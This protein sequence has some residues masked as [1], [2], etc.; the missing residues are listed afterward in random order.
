MPYK[1]VISNAIIAH[2]VWRSTL[3]ACLE[4]GQH[5]DADLVKVAADHHTC[6]F[7]IWLDSDEAAPL[8]YT[9]DYTLIHKMH[10]EFHKA[11]ADV[12]GKIVG[13]QKA[14]ANEMMSA[15]G[16]FMSSSVR[17]IDALTD[18]AERI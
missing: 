12:C 13:G 1:Q 9:R 11:A 10:R 6:E 8:R 15:S 2:R 14:E 7:G 17:L 3:K 5:V 4:D 18:W 16:P